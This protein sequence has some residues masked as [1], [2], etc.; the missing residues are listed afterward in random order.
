MQNFTMLKR[1]YLFAIDHRHITDIPT[2]RTV[3]HC[4]AV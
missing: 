1:V 3:S 2:E 4:K